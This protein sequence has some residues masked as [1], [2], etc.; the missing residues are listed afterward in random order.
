MSS[1]AF[2]GAVIFH[3]ATGGDWESAIAEGAY[4]PDGLE[5]EGF[6]HCSFAEQLQEVTD[7]FFAGRDD[8][9]LLMIDVTKLDPELRLEG[10]DHE[11][12]PFPHV[13]GPL[14]TEA[15]FQAEFYRPDEGRWF[16]RHVEVVA[17]ATHGGSTIEQVGERVRAT[18]GSFPR[19]W[20]VAGGWGVDLFLGRRTRPH[21]N[22]EVSILRSDLRALFDHL[23]G[24]DLRVA[25]EGTLRD[26]SGEDIE[27]SYHQIW[28]RRGP[29]RPG[30]VEDF[31]TDPTFLDVLIEEGGADRWAFRRR[32]SITRPLEAFGITTPEGV[33]IVSPEVALL[34]KA[35]GKRFKDHWDFDAAIPHLDGA[36]RSWLASALAEAHPGH[37]WMAK[38]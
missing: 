2:S 9:I 12:R 16:G 31:A 36:A 17:L 23:D 6:I 26:W 28:A 38:L 35:K 25:T 37:P 27:P 34:Y 8:L 24:W 5:R 11:G 7:A 29:V 1:E 20:W 15:V 32:T 18:M 4:A 21:A 10:A 14:E 3:L 30:D 13:Y 33:P 22:L 19:P